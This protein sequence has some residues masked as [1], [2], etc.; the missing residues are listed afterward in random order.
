MKKIHVLMSAACASLLFISCD[1]EVSQVT[2]QNDAQSTRTIQIKTS[3]EDLGSKATWV[4]GDGFNWESVADADQFMLGVIDATDPQL[5][6]S[7]AVAIDGSG[8]ALVTVTAP[9]TFDAAYLFYPRGSAYGQ[10]ANTVLTGSWF[11]LV[12]NQ[13]QAS[14]GT[15]ESTSGRM[16]M[17]S[18]AAISANSGS[19]SASMTCY[20]SLARFLV[21]SSADSDKSVKSVTINRHDGNKIWGQMHI[22]RFKDGSTTTEFSAV[23]SSENKVTLGTAMSLSGKTTKEDTE[24]IYLGL[25]PGTYAGVTYTVTMS[26]DTQYIFYSTADK[27]F[28]AGRIHNIYLNLTKATTVVPALS[29]TYLTNI[30]KDGETIASAATLG[31]TI[32]GVASAD[33]AAD[34]AAYGLSLTCT[35]G[36]T[37]TITNAAGNIQIVF[38]AN[39]IASTKEYT[40][41]ADWCGTT[42]SITFTQDAGSGGGPV[43]SYTF[44]DIIN[45]SSGTILVYDKGW[46]PSGNFWN[47]KNVKVDGVDLDYGNA[48]AIQDVL[49]FAFRI[50]DPGTDPAGYDAKSWLDGQFYVHYI[51]ANAIDGIAVSPAVGSNG[52]NKSRFAWYDCDGVELGY[53]YMCSNP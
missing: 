49:D 46:D 18:T 43:Y 50:T 42:S 7:S 11:N 25:Y 37:A 31:L 30:D 33:V 15:M 13:T 47:L 38:P 1:K 32:N 14:A 2:E 5:N 40:L 20:T 8:S 29:K 12:Q 27:D 26:D 3:V 34:A 9:A 39:A 51:F 53:V 45:W 48:S 17:A 22:L 35:G 6:N 28:V 23:G 4:D 36:A 41:T 19:Y 44:N 10:D 21:F 52:N 16:V 24:G